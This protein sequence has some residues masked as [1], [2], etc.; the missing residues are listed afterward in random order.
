MYFANSGR[1]GGGCLDYTTSLKH[2]GVLY[3]EFATF[4]NNTENL[5]RDLFKNTIKQID[6]ILHVRKDVSKQSCANS[7]LL[8]WSVQHGIRT[9]MGVQ[10]FLGVHRFTKILAFLGDSGW[11][12]LF[13]RHQ[14][15][16]LR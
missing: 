10:Y 1:R 2:L 14:L 6:R 16:M 8:Q 12:P 15:N 3:Y 4:K 13:Y 11:F 5:T 9:Y 7:R